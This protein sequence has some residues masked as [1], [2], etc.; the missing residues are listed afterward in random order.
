[1]WV[2]RLPKDKLLKDRG[3]ARIGALVFLL[4]VGVGQAAA[5]PSTPKTLIVRIPADPTLES[6]ELGVNDSIDVH[7][8]N[9]AEFSDAPI[10]IDTD[11]QITLPLTGRV[12]AAGLTVKQLEADLKKRLATYVIEP[13]V[14]VRLNEARSQ[15]VS[16]IGAVN[17]PGMLQLEGSRNLLEL[18]SLAGGLAQDAGHTVKITR[19]REW[20]AIPVSGASEDETHMF[21]VAEI[22]LKQLI[23]AKTPAANIVI[24]PFDVI[25]VQRAE[26]IYV[27]GDVRK[28][29]G[30]TLAQKESLSVLRAL[31]L[32]EGMQPSALG[33]KAK[34]IRQDGDA[35]RTE[36]P[37]DLGKL[38]SGKQQDVAMMPSDILFVPN[39]KARAITLKAIDSM[40]SVASGV[41]IYGRY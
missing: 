25:S 19:R 18:I 8:V 9:L 10:R 38:L 23:D 16:V 31:S 27:M 5:P 26:L 29:G 1:M 4:V 6:Y 33:S 3:I 32:A 35:Q 14:M 41:L 28:P 2:H 13:I 21:S 40:I 30:F 20:G 37:V 24:R 36:I 12:Q 7:C 15:P 11:G 17:K 22:D 39:N 34:I